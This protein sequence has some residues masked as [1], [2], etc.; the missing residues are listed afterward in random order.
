[1]KTFLTTLFLIALISP[2]I[3]QKMDTVV[4]Q[5]DGVMDS[6]YIS[7]I[8]EKTT[9]GLIVILGGFSSPQETLKETNLPFKACAAGYTV[10]LPYLYRADLPDSTGIFQSKLELLLPELM[11]RYKIPENRFIIGGQSWAGHQA[12]LYAE[13]AYDPSRK[14][15]I[16]P[17]LVFG[18]DPPLDLKRLYNG[19]IRAITIDPSKKKGS[20]A[21]MITGL[22]EKTFGGP[23]SQQPLAY[24]K[25]S[26]YYRDA[27]NG[28]NAKY[29]RTVPV[30][31]Y[32]DPDVEWY[33]RERNMPIEWSNTADITACIVQ[34]KLLGN[35]HA[36]YISCLGK[37]Y[38]PDGK[39]HPHAFS[40]LDADEFI[41]WADKMLPRASM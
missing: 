9:K 41:R 33:I 37:G 6:F 23:P 3:A 36:E 19:Y 34:L 15:I 4:H 10:V 5:K 32:S 35:Q 17:D 16:K 28:G 39:R 14:P 31:L 27:K 13:R 38:Q 40:M 24:E 12:M 7:L 2:T 21:A 8:P 30:R 25:A 1:M 22:F 20:E 26:S 29:L 11:E 18:V